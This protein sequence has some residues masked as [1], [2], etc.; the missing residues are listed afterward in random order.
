MINE[1]FNT[2]LQ[3]LPKYIDYYDSKVINV[4]PTAN[5]TLKY[6]VKIPRDEEIGPIMVKS[7]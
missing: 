2:H 7:F 3:K 5:T 6:L 1:A 4:L